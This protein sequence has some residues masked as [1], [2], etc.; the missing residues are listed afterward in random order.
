[1]TAAKEAGAASLAIVNVEGFAVAAPHADHVAAAPRRPRDAALPRPNPTSP[2]CP[3]IA[4]LVAA[5]TDDRGLKRSAQR[6]P[7]SRSSSAPVRPSGRRWSIRFPT[8]AG[9]SSSAAASASA[10]RRK[11]RSS[12]RK[13][14]AFMPRRS[15]P[16]NSSTG[17]WR[18]SA[19]AFRC[20][21]LRQSDE[22]GR[23]C[24]RSCRR[25]GGARRPR[26]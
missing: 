7:R 23:R 22:T 20:S 14:A 2:H 8:P 15:A 5:W 26:C 6:R 4:D 19:P 10:S 1:M 21:C 18:W 11:P 3:L 25:N 12:S 13:P 16:P 17:R 9:C 24:R